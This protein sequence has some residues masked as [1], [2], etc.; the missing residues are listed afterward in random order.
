MRS[1]AR[2]RDGLPHAELLLGLPGL[3]FE[4]RPAFGWVFIRISQSA[5]SLCIRWCHLVH[6][7]LGVPSAVL[8]DLLPAFQTRGV[9]GRGKVV[10]GVLECRERVRVSVCL[11]TSGVGYV[12]DG[13]SITVQSPSTGE[14]DIRM[15]ALPGWWGVGER[16]GVGLKGTER[17]GGKEANTCYSSI[18]RR[19][20]QRGGLVLLGV[21]NSD[22][23]W[24]AGVDPGG[25][26]GQRF[27]VGRRGRGRVSILARRSVLRT[28]KLFKRKEKRKEG[29]ISSHPFSR[30]FVPRFRPSL[31]GIRAYASPNANKLV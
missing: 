9:P 12:G 6:S 21:L 30:E 26:G 4:G 7:L 3:Y 5:N 22:A 23:W 28:T 16:K 24:P 15:G 18:F 10:E 20:V 29:I 13:R 31:F 1:S 27:R 19:F 11:H 2:S 25:A 17:A 14:C 8:R